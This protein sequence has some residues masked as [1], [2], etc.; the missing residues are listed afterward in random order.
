MTKAM[1]ERELEHIKKMSPAD[2]VRACGLID[3][4]TGRKLTPAEVER[5]AR[6][7]EKTSREQQG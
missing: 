4:K 1:L 3:N 5:V 7:M 2:T 6:G